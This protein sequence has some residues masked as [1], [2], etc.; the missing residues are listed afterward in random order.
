MCLIF[1]G[2]CS[3]HLL[4]IV[5]DA[6]NNK[7]KALLSWEVRFKAAVGIAEALDYLHHECSPL[8]IHRDVKSSNIL[9][10]PELEP[11]VSNH[12]KN[13]MTNI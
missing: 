11:R 13:N 9:L 10:T 4:L 6:G 2:K 8:V 7:G 5:V 12:R 1:L 3:K